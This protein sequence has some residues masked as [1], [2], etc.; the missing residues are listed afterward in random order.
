MSK[1]YR[2]ELLR[3]ASILKMRAIRLRATVDEPHPWDAVVA[4]HDAARKELAA[5]ALL[6]NPPLEV[7][8]RARIEACGLFLDARDPE[9]ATV[10]WELIP[11]SISGSAAGSAM[12]ARLKPTFKKEQATF[13]RTW[14]EFKKELP[15]SGS[16]EGA[17]I[18]TIRKLCN[19]YPGIA[20][21]WWIAYRHADARGRWKEAKHA[22]EHARRLA[23]D[24]VRYVAL[25]IFLASS[26]LA[27][28]KA[29]AACR[30]DWEQFRETSAEVNQ[31]FALSLLRL[32]RNSP[33]RAKLIVEVHDAVQRAEKL[34][35]GTSLGIQ[36][37]L[38]HR[39][40]ELLRTGRTPTAE[41]FMRFGMVPFSTVAKKFKLD[42]FEEALITYCAPYNDNGR[43][44][45]AAGF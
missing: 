5:L 4:F 28:E 2:D 13:V 18:G 22:L 32:S 42:E 19:A 33:L 16:F 44:P 43:I 41:D 36:A 39:Y 45:A 38:L 24:N 34:A 7:E 15:R 20:G 30:K 11:V 12:L 9:S 31:M 21:F 23:P 26:V 29:L 35:A 10:Q 17:R 6:D 37:N 40:V 27:P 8:A 3:E 14:T 25:D 1:S